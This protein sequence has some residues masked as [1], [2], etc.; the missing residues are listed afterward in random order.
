MKKYYYVFEPEWA[1]SLPELRWFEAKSFGA[2]RIQANGL[3]ADHKFQR[4]FWNA[5]LSSQGIAVTP[6]RAL[7]FYKEKW[8]MR[9]A[10]AQESISLG[11]LRLTQIP[12]TSTE[13][14]A[15]LIK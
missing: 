2:D 8:L 4:T 10:R 12:G 1:S 9:I 7:A 6:E 14:C 5:C 15:A 11:R 3:V 13:A